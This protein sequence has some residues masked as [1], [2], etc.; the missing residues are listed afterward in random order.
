MQHC[1]IY[2]ILLLSLS[3]S[4]DNQF[5]SIN[6]PSKY[7]VFISLCLAV[8]VANA[9]LLQDLH[10]LLAHQHDTTPHCEADYSESHI[11]GEEFLATNCIV[12]C[13]Q[14]SPSEQTAF[15]FSVDLPSFSNEDAFPLNSTILLG[16]AVL[17]TAPR[18][19]PTFIA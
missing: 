15:S 16:K 8:L 12:C 6:S 1:Y 13:F 3:H 2:K 18:G 11:H 19:P 10:R 5:I 4:F 9:V 7:R 17:I 14:F